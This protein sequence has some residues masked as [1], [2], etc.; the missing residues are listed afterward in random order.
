LYE[1]LTSPMRAICTPI[2]A[3]LEMIMKRVTYTA[4]H[5]VV[6]S[7]LPPLTAT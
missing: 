3:P 6:F 7:S 1:F 4:P 2:S 5:H